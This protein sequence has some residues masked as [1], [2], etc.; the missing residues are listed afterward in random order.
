VVVEVIFE[1]TRWDFEQLQGFNIQRISFDITKTSYV[2]EFANVF[3]K[4][5][6]NVLGVIDAV[7]EKMQ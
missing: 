3:M 6:A 4:Q 5:E 2:H 1:F 7:I